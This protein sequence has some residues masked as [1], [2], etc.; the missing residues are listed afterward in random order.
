MRAA[1]EWDTGEPADCVAAVELGGVPCVSVGTYVYD[2]ATRTRSGRLRIHAAADLRAGVARAA[3]ETPRGP[4]V[5]DALWDGCAAA[6]AQSDGALAV[7]EWAPAGMRLRASVAV[8][9]GAVLTAVARGGGGHVVATSAGGVHV[10]APD[11]SVC[12]VGRHPAEAWTAA[13]D[14][15][16]PHVVHSGDDLGAWHAWDARCPSARPA[17]VVRHHAAGLCCIAPD[18]SVAG[19]IATSSYDRSVALWD[20]RSLAR[21]VAVWAGV[22]AAGVWRLAWRGAALLAACM[23]DGARV[24]AVAPDGAISVRAHAAP[25]DTPAGQAL[26]YGAA[27]LDDR[28]AVT[29]SFYSHT[30]HLWAL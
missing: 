22:S 28:T 9:R 8:E 24:L 10:V 16:S 23:F 1:L 30:A 27:W 26:T 4:G 14:A 17:S 13:G 25:P 5:Y 2:E 18:P 6:L 11:A 15:Q 7:W 20:A 12:C 29:S 3:W 21:P 19:R